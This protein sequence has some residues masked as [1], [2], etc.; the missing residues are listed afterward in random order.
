MTSA[1][2]G[3]LGSPFVVNGFVGS[4]CSCWTMTSMGGTSACAAVD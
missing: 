3:S 1:L 4:Y 2:K